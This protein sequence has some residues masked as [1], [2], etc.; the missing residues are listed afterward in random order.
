MLYLR[1]T[2]HFL[3]KTTMALW[4]RYLQLAPERRGDYAL[5]LRDRLK[6]YDAAAK[7]FVALANSMIKSP[8]D[9]QKAADKVHERQNDRKN[10]QSEKTGSGE[11]AE[12]D[13]SDEENDNLFMLNKTVAFE[14]AAD[15]WDALC[16]LIVDHAH[17]ISSVP[18]ESIFRTALSVFKRDQ[19]RYWTAFAT[20]R[21]RL[22]DFDAARA[23]FEEAFAQ[24]TMIRD[25]AQIFDS[26]S[27]MEEALLNAQIT[28][29]LR[30]RPKGK[31][32]DIPADMIA[33]MKR[34]QSLI[35]RHS[36]L[37]NDVHLR[38]SPHSVAHWIH[39]AELFKK[40]SQH[41]Q[42]LS[43][44]ETASKSVS[45]KRASAGTY[46]QLWI[47]WARY[48][49]D[50]KSADEA[51]SIFK[52]ATESGKIY[53]DSTDDL[54]A[55]YLAWADME[56]RLACDEESGL[57]Q[58]IDVLSRAIA[59]VS[60]RQ[61]SDAH[62]RLHRSLTIWNAYLDL[63]E[64]RGASAA[65]EAA[66]ERLLQLRVAQPQHVINY[67]FWLED[68]QKNLDGAFRVYERGIEMFGYPV[69][70]EIWNIYLPKFMTR[71]GST[72]LERTRDL[73][74]S[75]IHGC[76]EKFAKT[77][78]LLYTKL[79]EE[80]GLQRN[81]LK[82]LR[83]ACSIVPLTEKAELYSL[84][85]KKTADS[86]GLLATRQV[87]EEA[88]RALPQQQ[89]L[90]LVM[91][92]ST[93]EE[94]LDDINRARALLLHAAPF[95]DPR[96]CEKFWSHWQEFEGRHGDEKTLREMLRVKRSV[97]H[98]FQ[99]KSPYVPASTEANVSEEIANE[100]IEND[101]EIQLDL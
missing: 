91:R 97:Q 37:L 23:V 8:E 46:P 42:V 21:L 67:A 101:E 70:F 10:S 86:L 71:Y 59:P 5:F 99:S 36:L 76:P 61:I 14:D 25:F 48:W 82:I 84:L 9:L 13:T 2:Y 4:S 50:L 72:R 63:E 24:V 39:R 41:E 58:A 49:E 80:H 16:E 7:E 81:A 22:G 53:F 79:E 87:Y 68:D 73:F 88:I 66:Y 35:N 85:A 26:Y 20:F 69:A 19:G 31:D 54:A 94:K 29:A 98:E 52:H 77:L 100:A 64:T 18:V 57:N 55:V 11:T 15:C 74:E 34:L 40:R 56:R 32:H 75:A 12:S 62:Q 38:Q 96:S 89:A 27:K 43:T 17:E 45:P 83:R 92:Y 90:D 3:P 95:A 47:A 30:K 33:Q 1:E 28:R 6:N 93:L 78:Y 60:K 44:F 51:R 65:I